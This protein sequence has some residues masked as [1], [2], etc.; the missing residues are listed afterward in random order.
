MFRGNVL[1]LKAHPRVKRNGSDVQ[2]GSN[3]ANHR[4]SKTTNGV[5]KGRVEAASKTTSTIIGM[6]R[7]KVDVCLVRISLGDE[8]CQKGNDFAVLLDGKTRWPKMDK[9][10]PWQQLGQGS[11]TKPIIKNRDNRVVVGFL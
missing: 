7:N 5:E 9:E 3:T 8:A 10:N 4:A 1:D 6:N 11:T 2:R